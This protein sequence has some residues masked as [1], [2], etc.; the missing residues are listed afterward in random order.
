L[1]L[2]GTEIL[3]LGYNALQ[4]I[5]S[6]KLDGG[7]R[8]LRILNLEGN[9]IEYTVG[10]GQMQGLERLDLSSNQ[11]TGLDLPLGVRFEK[12]KS[13]SL[14]HNPITHFLPQTFRGQMPAIKEFSFSAEGP[15]ALETQMAIL[16]RVG[17]P[18]VL[19]ESY[20]GN[21]VYLQFATDRR[22]DQGPL[23][24]VYRQRDYSLPP[25]T[26]EQAVLPDGTLVIR[27]NA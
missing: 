27:Y 4:N 1:D 17:L 25:G 6:F 19:N 3:D 16:D 14:V 22:Y 8:S 9:R 24:E 23:E 12:M 11:L 21:Q 7:N 18:S 15:Q 10:I 20:L 5:S 2:P 13:L 26:Y